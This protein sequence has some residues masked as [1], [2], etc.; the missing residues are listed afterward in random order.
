MGVSRDEWDRS[1]VSSQLPPPYLLMLK[2]LPQYL[3]GSLVTEGAWVKIMGGSSHDVL[4]DQERSIVHGF[5]LKFL[6]RPYLN[7]A[8]M[9]SVA[10]VVEGLGK[11][12]DINSV[13]LLRLECMGSANGL[14]NAES[15]A[16]LG[17][18]IM[19]GELFDVKGGAMEVGERVVDE[20]LGME[21]AYTACGY[22]DDRFKSR[23]MK[24]WKGWAG[25]AGSVLQWNEGMEVAFGYNTVL[26]YMRVGKPRGIRLMKVVEEVVRGV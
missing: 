20:G 23:G 6:T 3:L 22:G 4:E 5:L 11:I 12:E 10:G 25:M 1:S 19:R 9:G 7:F 8:A 2:Y 16:R 14:A 18:L 15:M 24:G 26:P 17:D 13:P 21:I